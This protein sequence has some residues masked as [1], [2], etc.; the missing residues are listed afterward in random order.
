MTYKYQGGVKK[1]TQK[2]MKLKTLKDIDS[3]CMNCADLMWL[4]KE[5]IK[6]VKSGEYDYPDILV[7]FCN[8]TEEDLQ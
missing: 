4:K 1:D 7:D 3:N 6:W 5:A 2:S 8:I